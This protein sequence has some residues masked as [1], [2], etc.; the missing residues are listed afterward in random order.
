MA[1]DVFKGFG[2]LKLVVQGATVAVGAWSI[3]FDYSPGTSLTLETAGP[4]DAWHRTDKDCNIGTDAIEWL[5]E[6][7]PRVAQKI[8]SI[9]L[10]FRASEFPDRKLLVPYKIDRTGWQWGD[11]PYSENVQPY[12]QHRARE[13]T[14]TP[15]LEKSSL[16]WAEHESWRKRKEDAKSIMM[17]VVSI[18]VILEIFSRI[19]GWIVRGFVR[20]NRSD[21]AIDEEG[22]FRAP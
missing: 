3:I 19:L 10:C 11:T 18:V 9:G 1:V 4:D 15:Q 6:V 5:D 17:T 22:K 12:T 20:P 8:S 7:P 13:F 16:A 2:R 21:S 14:F